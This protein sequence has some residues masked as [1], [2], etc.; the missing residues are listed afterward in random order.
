MATE[1]PPTVATA[2]VVDTTLEAA[3][4]PDVS[5]SRFSYLN[6]AG[7]TGILCPRDFRFSAYW[8]PN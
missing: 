2:R 7:N 3:I 6:Q 5:T 8:G 1:V 4:K